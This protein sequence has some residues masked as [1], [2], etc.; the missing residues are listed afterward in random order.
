MHVQRY[1]SSDLT[2]FWGGTAPRLRWSSGGPTKAGGSDALE[3]LITDLRFGCRLSPDG[4]LSTASVASLHQLSD[5]VVPNARRP[6]RRDP[7]ATVT[8]GPLQRVRRPGYVLCNPRWRANA[9]AAPA[10][11]RHLPLKRKLVRPASLGPN[12]KALP[13]V[14]SNTGWTAWLTSV[15]NMCIDRSFQDGGNWAVLDCSRVSR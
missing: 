1:V 2:H 3:A 8:W 6:A 5:G 11:N 14:T 13:D 15:S 7:S 12:L 10:E 4:E 9:S